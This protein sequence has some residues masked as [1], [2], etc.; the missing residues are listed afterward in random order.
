MKTKP[1]IHPNTTSVLKKIQHM[2]RPEPWRPYLVC[3]GYPT[4]DAW[5]FFAP[6]GKIEIRGCNEVL[7]NLLPLFDGS[8]DFAQIMNELA[9]TGRDDILEVIA[10]LVDRQI[11]VDANHV[12][13]L[14]QSYAS[15]PAPFSLQCSHEENVAN[16]YDVSH[17][18]SVR[19][20]TLQ[21]PI[22]KTCL[23]RL[24]RKRTTC[25]RFSGES[26]T[27][28]E[29]FELVWTMYGRQ[30]EDRVPAPPPALPTF[31]VPSG[32]GLYPLSL[33]VLLAKPCGKLSP[34]VYLWHKEDSLLERVTEADP[35]PDLAQMLIGVQAETARQAAGVVCVVADFERT[36]K[37]YGNHAYNL[38]L[39]EAGHVM[40]NAYLYGSENQVGI[41]EVYG[42]LRDR[43]ASL[44]G[45]EPEEKSPVIACLFGRPAEAG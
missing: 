1:G 21:V 36:A 11:V 37:K 7:A 38:A 19:G 31:T 27:D 4:H 17:L 25:R 6:K 42:F 8:G 9:Q 45:V 16:Y 2:M 32:G 35:S 12:F 39:L 34:G 20:T 44:L 28:T 43:L 13:K 3:G 15:Y 26:V 30:D 24:A 10:T 5:V 18:P 22:R 29:V 40:Q 33:Y 23:G 41:L 14:F